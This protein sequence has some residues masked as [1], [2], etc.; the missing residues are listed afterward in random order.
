MPSQRPTG[1]EPLYVLKPVAPDVWIVD[2]ENIRFY[3]LPFSTRMTI[4]RLTNDDIWVH[5]PIADREELFN[6][7]TALGPVRHLIAPN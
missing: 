6:A 3:G 1:Y 2:G 7:V 5:S 4:V